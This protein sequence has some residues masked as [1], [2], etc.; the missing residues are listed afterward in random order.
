LKGGDPMI[1][2]RGGE[3]CAVLAEAGIAHEVVNG[4]TAGLAAASALGIPLT[5]REHCHG[6][7]FVTGTERTAGRR[8]WRRSWPLATRSWSTWEWRAAARSARRCSPP[9]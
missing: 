3:E 4:I 1:F 2:G 6:V 9:A 5:H 7:A 8:Y